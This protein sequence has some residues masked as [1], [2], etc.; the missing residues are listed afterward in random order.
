MISDTLAA[1]IHLGNIQITGMDIAQVKSDRHLEK[2]AHL[3][4]VPPKLLTRV[5][6]TREFQVGLDV[7]YL[8]NT[9]DEARSNNISLIRHLYQHVFMVSSC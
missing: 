5:L 6:T 2:A 9:A 1:I 4:K 7:Q 8:V 3:I